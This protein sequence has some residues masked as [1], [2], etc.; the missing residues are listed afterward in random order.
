M[1]KKGTN[2]FLIQNKNL[3]KQLLQKKEEKFVDDKLLNRERRRADIPSR[4]IAQKYTQQ[5][6]NEMR[7]TKLE[8]NRYITHRVYVSYV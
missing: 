4:S 5:K 7:R 3:E 6:P 8:A 2:Y 1:Y